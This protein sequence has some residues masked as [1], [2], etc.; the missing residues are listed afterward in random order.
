MKS[1][2]VSTGAAAESTLASKIPLA[3][4]AK[5][6]IFASTCAE[7]IAYRVVDV[8]ACLGAVKARAGAANN[9]MESFMFGAA[10]GRGRW[11]VVFVGASLSSLHL[12]R[13]GA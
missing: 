2:L 4:A 1:F 5:A 6:S 9:A 8:D 10:R 12:T 13:V 3:S 7:S 11:C